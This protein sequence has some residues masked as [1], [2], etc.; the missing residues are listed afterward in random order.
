MT[1]M[2]LRC[3]FPLR[4]G[5]ARLRLGIPAQLLSLHGRRRV[6]LLDLSESGARLRYDGEP[7]SDV[8]LEWLGYEAFGKVVRRAGDELGVRFDEPIGSAWVLE[9]RERLPAI[10]QGEDQVTRFA[11]EWARG[12]DLD[13]NAAPADHRWSVL[14]YPTAA[15]KRGLGQ[16]APGLRS[17]LGTA[18]PFL[19]GGA[20]IGLLVG[21]GSSFF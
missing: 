11:R 2:A 18:K 20:I 1:S 3:H 13:A 21:Y 9:T 12:R 5:K 4:R 7:V 10:A 16:P 19:L 8:I 15:R 14:G 6:T 17:W